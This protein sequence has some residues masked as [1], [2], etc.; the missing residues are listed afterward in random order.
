MLHTAAPAEPTIEGYEA[1]VLR[2]ATADLVAAFPFPHRLTL[3][4]T[5]SGRTLEMRTTLKPTGVTP[6]PVSFGFHPYLR[7]PGVA[8]RHWR[9]ELPALRHLEVDH[10][11]LPTGKAEPVV[12][13]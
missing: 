4:A 6:V 7:I 8:R 12:A 11:G 3:D 5:L 10:L 1:L 2:S 9:V 13:W